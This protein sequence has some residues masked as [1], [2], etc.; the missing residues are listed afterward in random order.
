MMHKPGFSPRAARGCAAAAVFALVGGVGHGQEAPPQVGQTAPALR[1]PDLNGHRFDL[2]SL[3][4]KVVIVNFWA[5]WCSPCRAEMPVLDA[6]YQSHHAQG[7]ELLGLSIDDPDDRT[8][9]ERV[10]QHFSFPAGLMSQSQENGF[11][12][13]VAVPFTYVIDSAGVIRGRIPPGANGIT[14]KLLAQVVTP[15]LAHPK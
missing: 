5:T 8:E 13:P 11:G 4:G 1:L 10:M 9:V 2:A 6:F 14:P 3:R 15:L 12:T 7:L